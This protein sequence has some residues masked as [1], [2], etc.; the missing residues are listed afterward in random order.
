[1]T[2]QTL[3]PTP[4]AVDTY[5]E[6]TLLKPDQVLENALAASDVAGLPRHAVSPLQGQF[7]HILIKAT[8]ARRIL[9]IGTLGG[10][11][12]IC[13]ARAL[14]NGGKLISLEFDPVCARVASQNIELAGLSEHVRIVEGAA[15]DSLTAMISSSEPPFDLIFIDA[16]KPSNP[17]YL[18]AALKLSRKGTIIIGDNVVRDGAVA[19]DTSDD[20]KVIGVRTFL[21]AIG[22]NSHLV[23]T[24]MQT[25]G[26]KGHDGFSMAI[27]T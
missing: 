21:D 16:D 25:V 18:E 26:S 19:D 24:A 13:M 22:Q 7:L 14:P 10:Y 12:T 23:A 5:F 4:A 8:G 11:S 2:L 9:E 15:L 27:V 6:A 20:P 1:M 17:D 3:G